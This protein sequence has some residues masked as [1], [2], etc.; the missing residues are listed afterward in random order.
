MPVAERV[1]GLWTRRGAYSREVMQSFAVNLLVAGL[2]ALSGYLLARVLGPEGRGELAAIQ[3]LPMIVANV[4]M[5]GLQDAVIYFGARDRERVGHYAV[6]SA[7]LIALI[8]IPL[9]VASALLMPLYLRDYGADTIF[10]SRIHLVLLFLQALFGVAIFASRA[11]HDIATWNRLRLSM[12]VLWVAVIAALAALGRATPASLVAVHLIAYAV[13][14]AVAVAR[15]RPYLRGGP[16]LD[17]K[18]WRPMLAYGL[19][20]ALGSAPQVVSQRLDQ[21]II[22]GLLSARELGFYAVAVSWSMLITLPGAAFHSV[23]FSKVAALDDRHLQWAFLRRVLL[24]V[25]ATTV[26][27][28]LALGLAAPWAIDLLLGDAFAPAAPVAIVLLVAGGLRNVVML[29]QVGLMSVGRP[30][31]VLY[32]EGAGL[33]A[34]APTLPW[35]VGSHGLQGGAVAVVVSRVVAVAVATVVVRAAFRP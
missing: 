33:L 9:V 22:A 21:L 4:G 32:A 25:V 1:R 6:S 27:A 34:L 14:A 18:L 8:G 2:N 13:W 10:W 11:V 5:L 24:A 15:V 7:V 28:G 12:P 31:G 16:R 17:R 3:A 26:A 35:L 30:R 19:P 29:L 20:L 23:A